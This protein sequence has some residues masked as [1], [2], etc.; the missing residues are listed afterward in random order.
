MSKKTVSFTIEGRIKVD[1]KV[2]NE[3]IEEFLSFHY[4]IDGTCDG[5]NPLLEDYEAEESIKLDSV[6]VM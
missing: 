1:Q 6:D 4:D 5:E 2:T 3:Q